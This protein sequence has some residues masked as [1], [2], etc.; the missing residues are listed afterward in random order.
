[1]IK[2]RLILDR[3]DSAAKIVFLA[4]SDISLY[5]TAGF[6]DLHLRSYSI[7]TCL[8]KQLEITSEVAGETTPNRTISDFKRV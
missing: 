8:K 5:V 1:L 6:K 4:P 7:L 2:Q 3:G